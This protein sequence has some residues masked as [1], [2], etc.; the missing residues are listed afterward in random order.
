MVWPLAPV[1]VPWN[2]DEEKSVP[3]SAT[4]GVGAERP[5]ASC[6]PGKRD[7][8]LGP[9][10][11]ERIGK[12]AAS[13]PAPHV[14]ACEL[15]DVMPSAYE[16]TTAAPPLSP[17]RTQASVTTALTVWFSTPIAVSAYRMWPHVHPLVEP[18]LHITA[19][20]TPVVSPRIVSDPAPGAPWP[21]PQV[22]IAGTPVKAGFVI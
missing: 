1:V 21:P 13:S 4:V 18:D 17:F 12:N 11:A 22:E 20:G 8:T 15:A 9:D 3:P 19:P 16:P 5:T 14:E 10:A 6:Q 2:G 7:S